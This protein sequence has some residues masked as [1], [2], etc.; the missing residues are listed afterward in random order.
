MTSGQLWE[1]VGGGSTGGI[2]VRAG[3]ETSSAAESSRLSL[4]A[5]VRELELEGDRL[6]YQRLTGTGPDTGWVSVKLKDG[7]ELLIKSEKAASPEAAAPAEPVAV[8]PVAAPTVPA[9][10]TSATSAAPAL[11]PAL[12]A[13]AKWTLI[14]TDEPSRGQQLRLLFAATATKFEDK[15]LRGDD[16]ISE[17][18]SESAGDSSPLAFNSLPV[19]QH[20]PRNISTAAAAMQYAGESLGLGDY[21]ELGRSRAAMIVIGCE[22]MRN[23]AFWPAH[24]R[25]MKGKKRI[26][27]FPKEPYDRWMGHFERYLRTSAAAAEMD[28]VDTGPFILGKKLCYGDLSLYDC[29]TS[30]WDL[31]CYGRDETERAHRFPCLSALVSAVEKLPFFKKYGRPHMEYFNT[32]VGELQAAPASTF[33]KPKEKQLWEVVGGGAQNGILVRKG[34]E[35]SSAAEPDRLSTG[36]MIREVLLDG[37]RLQYKRLSGTGPS[38]GWVSIRLKDKELVVKSSKQPPVQ[39]PQPLPTGKWQVL[40]HNHGGRGQQMR[41]MFHFAGADFEDKRLPSH[42]DADSFKSKV[43]GDASP[44]A[45]DLM[46]IVQHGSYNI[47]TTAGA[48]QYIGESLGL[49]GADELSRATALMMVI[50]SELMRNEVFYKAYNAMG[51]K[52]RRLVTYDSGAYDTWLSHFERLLRTSAD[53]GR[54]AGLEAG[55]FLLG[56]RICFADLAFYD[57]LT[58]IWDLGCYGRDRAERSQKF[59]RICALADA[60]AAQPSLQK[61]GQP[62]ADEFQMYGELPPPRT[63]AED[64]PPPPT[65]LTHRDRL[66]QRVQEADKTLK[67]AGGKL[68]EGT[69]KVKIVIGTSAMAAENPKLAEEL[70]SIVNRSNEAAIADAPSRKGSHKTVTTEEM[71]GRLSL[72]DSGARCNRVL[73]VAMQGNVPVGC[74]TSSLRTPW[75]E[76]GVGHWG[77]LSVDPKLQ[78]KGYASA[79]VAHAMQRL[80]WDCTEVHIEFLHTRKHAY[81]DR[82]KD[83]Y[84]TKMGFQV[85]SAQTAGQFSANSGFGGDAKD[86]ILRICRKKFT[87]EEIALGRRRRAQAI[88]AE[89]AAQ[90]AALSGPGPALSCRDVFL[91]LAAFVKT[92]G[93]E[94]AA[95]VS[96]AFQFEVVDAGSDGI[97]FVD[98]R[99]GLRFAGYGI[100]ATAECKIQVNDAD[101]DPFLRGEISLDSGYWSGRLV[102]TDDSDNAK[103]LQEIYAS[104]A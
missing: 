33:V 45:F 85:V 22:S 66:E 17:L 11:F 73:H 48:M 50:G 81:S 95:K 38:T 69:A 51:Q 46:P 65:S 102:I 88:H 55:P 101:L 97:F 16:E 93:A 37:E 62:H 83:W 14:T 64:P 57:C 91:K 25:M 60:I 79:L 96:A 43:M 92:A 40:Y 77:F 2:L 71:R 32:Q 87:S 80:A 68:S 30:L 19:V 82:L 31:G 36:A 41:L 49:G 15:R 70:A 53:A 9:A 5:L 4:G 74:M 86:T 1:V 58:S 18:K 26:N 13:D 24:E 99:P 39:L 12:P 59:P 34:K 44:L 47:A 8:E 27:V 20:G 94:V 61:Y 52:K 90:L 76:A 23:E 21:D 3:K 75:T 35:T 78:G 103:K 54:A 67:D 42:D 63:P 56:P 10:A 72:G 28:S 104:I 84:E 7:K 98:F 89:L 29:I 100:E 6:R